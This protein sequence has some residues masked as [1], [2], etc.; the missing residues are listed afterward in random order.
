[1]GGGGVEVWR[2]MGRGRGNVWRVCEMWKMCGGVC[3]GR[4]WSVH[5]GRLYGGDVV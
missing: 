3:V 1:M 4:V 5:V 2:G